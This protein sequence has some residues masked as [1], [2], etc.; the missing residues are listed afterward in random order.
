[1]K[2]TKTVGALAV[3][4]LLLTGCQGMQQEK[5]A[6][7]APAVQQAAASPST[8]PVP[9][10]M[11]GDS[12]QYSDGY[13]IRVSEVAADG[14]TKFDRTDVM[15]QWTIRQAFFKHESQ[16][17][18]T[19]RL[20]VFRTADPMELFKKGINEPVTFT[21]EYTRNGELVRHRTSWVVEGKER[22]QVP[23]GTFDTWVIVWRSQSLE[24]AWRGFERWYYAPEVRNYVRIEYKY[25]ESPD[26][27]RVLMKYS[28][29]KPAGS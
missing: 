2:A 11:V 14:K 18:R 29:A 1:M 15:G 6:T 24:S 4:A 25:G 16:T 27:A 26:S 13:G 17:R 20:V 21:R 12:W 22:I 9:R 23:A 5:P 28:L 8:V 7:Q 19:H 3:G 10:W